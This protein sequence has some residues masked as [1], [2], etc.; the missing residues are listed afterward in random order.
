MT[1]LFHPG[2]V[3]KIPG[4]VLFAPEPPHAVV[5]GREG[6]VSPLVT[7]CHHPRAERQESRVCPRPRLASLSSETTNEG[8]S[9]RGLPGPQSWC[10]RPRRRLAGLCRGRSCSDHGQALLSLL[11]GGHRISPRSARPVVKSHL[12]SYV[13]GE[14]LDCDPADFRRER[15]RPGLLPGGRAPGRS[16]HIFPAP[17]G[18]RLRHVLRA[19]LLR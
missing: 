5:Q 11:Q 14:P 19:S 15:H 12:V 7:T 4:S 10:N 8:N 17:L 16:G 1:Q 3:R 9:F 13:P 6:D 18:A 2:C